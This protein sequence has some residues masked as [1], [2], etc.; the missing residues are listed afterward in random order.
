MNLNL[1]LQPILI[2]GG[3]SGFLGI[4]LA[5]CDKLFADYGTCKIIIN[6]NAE[7]ALEVKGGDTLLSALLS[8]KIF[9]PAACGGKATCGFCKVQVKSDV[10]EVLPT[11]KTWLTKKDI[12]NGVRLA[13]QVKVKHDIEIA[14]PEELLHVQEFT[15]RVAGITDLTHD[16]KGFVFKLAHPPAIS[17]KPGQ[18]IQFK[19][20]G[21]DEYRGYSL[22]N[23]PTGQDSEIELMVRLIP[24]GLCTPYMHNELEVGDEVTFTGPYGDFYLRED[25]DREIVCI[26]GGC[27]V[28]P[29]KSIVTYLFNKKSQRT[30]WFF[31]GARQTRDIYCADIF[32]DMQARYKNFSFIVALSHAEPGEGWTGE[33]GFIHGAVDKYISEGS[34]KDCYLCGPPLMIDACMKVLMAKGIPESQIYFD[35]F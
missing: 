26:A 24:G 33:T 31:F 13:C 12:R 30:V 28:A 16:I 21:T 34:E 8:N 35:K 25:T 6:E 1:V 14:V 9:I 4:V 29:I 17:F 5:I 3:I 27:G 15:G 2:L 23:M 18:Y 22:A 19:I 20:P 11:E 32:G 7:G 10:G